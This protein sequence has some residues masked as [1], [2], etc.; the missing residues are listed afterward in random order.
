MDSV[1]EKVCSILARRSK[2]AIIVYEQGLN[3]DNDD[4]L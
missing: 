4:L 1:V 2:A 3:I